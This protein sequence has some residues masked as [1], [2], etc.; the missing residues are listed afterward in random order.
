MIPTAT[1]FPSSRRINRPNCG[2]SLK[3]KIQIGCATDMRAIAAIP[4]FKNFGR[5]CIY[6]PSLYIF[7][8]EEIRHHQPLGSFSDQLVPATFQSC[9]PQLLHVHA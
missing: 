5:F 4:G 7:I 8:M 6:T 9:I 1:V 3:G 2:N